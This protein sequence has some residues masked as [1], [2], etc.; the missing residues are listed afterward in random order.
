MVRRNNMERTW[1]KY[2]GGPVITLVAIMLLM[3]PAGSEAVIDGVTGTTFT[4]TAKPGYISTGEG[5]T[6]FMWGYALDNGQM[7]YTGPTLIV[8]EGQVITITL[9][10]QL[11]VPV[12]VV[13]PGQS[14][15]AAG[16]V[17]GILTQEALPGGSV[18]YTFTASPG[19]YVYHSGTEPHLQVEMGLIGALIVRPTLGANYAYN[20]TATAFDHEYMFLHTEVDHV[21][22]Q[23]VEM[24]QM[25]SARNRLAG[26]GLPPP[27]DPAQPDPDV[28]W[29]TYW[30]LN[31]RNAPDNLS[32]SFAAW[33]PTQPYNC[34]AR[35]FPGDAV[36]LR[37]IGGDRDHHAFHPHGNDHIVIARDGRMLESNPGVSGPDLSYADFTTTTVPGETVDALFS[38]TGEGLNFDIY[39]DPTDPATVHT[40]VDVAVS[41]EPS[42]DPND[43]FDDVSWEYCPDHGK[44]IPVT[45]PDLKDLTFGQ[46]YSGSPFLGTFST[47]PPGEGGFNVNGGLFFM[48]HTHN[49]KELT[50]FDIFPGGM[51]SFVVIEPRKPGVTIP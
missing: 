27:D 36:L 48:W 24:G 33:L 41:D 47:L 29:P 15:A 7:Q 34:L 23:R 38:W 40:C 9:N 12:S 44:P 26:K 46:W 20:D 21:V 16:G 49:E 32:P 5:N 1:I 14:V 17:P 51:L 45:L 22:H 6:V 30:F 19:T 2:I 4:L 50:N 3:L 13:I 35:T 11:S 10:N 18:T 43:E 31:G 37:I 42:T 28:Y 25:S 39:G 8:N